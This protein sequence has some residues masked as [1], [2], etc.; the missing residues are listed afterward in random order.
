VGWGVGQALGGG[1]LASGLPDPAQPP[2]FSEWGEFG[3]RLARGTVS[4]F[5]AGLTTAALRGGKYSAAQVVTDAFG[6][7]LGE[8]LAGAMEQSSSSVN[9]SAGA[10][11]SIGQLPPMDMEIAPGRND[12]EWS[13]DTPYAGPVGGA[14]GYQGIPTGGLPTTGNG[15]PIDALGRV[16]VTVGENGGV[17]SALRGADIDQRA[18]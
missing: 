18:G 1:T 4:G 14:Y 3:G 6:N 10:T 12:N 16:T 11:Q 13:G 9:G 5:A 15:L 7:A 8:S 17:L 2:A